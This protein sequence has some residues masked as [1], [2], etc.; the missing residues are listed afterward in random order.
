MTI[1]AHTSLVAAIAVNASQAADPGVYDRGDYR[2][3]QVMAMVISRSDAALDAHL[4]GLE[5]APL[6]VALELHKD[7]LRRYR[8]SADTARE[9]Y[10]VFDHASMMAG[11]QGMEEEA[12]TL[13]HARDE[14]RR[15]ARKLHAQYLAD[16][17]AIAF[18]APPGAIDRVRRARDRALARALVLPHTATEIID[19]IALAR[20]LADPIDVTDLDKEAPTPAVVLL[21]FERAAAPSCTRIIALAEGI[22]RNAS[23]AAARGEQYTREDDASDRQTIARLVEEIRS[24]T[25]RAVAR[26]ANMLPD[27][28]RDQWTLAYNE[29]RW[30]EA[31]EPGPFEA[32]LRSIPRLQNLTDAQR[33]QIDA[34][35][36]QYRRAVD[37]VRA[38]YA[39]CNDELRAAIQ[40]DQQAW[41]QPDR[42]GRLE[43]RAAIDDAIAKVK[44]AKADRETIAK[45]YLQRLLGVL[46]PA[47]AEKLEPS[48]K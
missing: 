33:E 27:T 6:A 31:Y 47:Q 8:D 39:R 28:Q 2:M 30:P 32:V 40:A 4:L 3:R 25:D 11:G 43:R 12:K 14:H 35:R 5:G 13:R 9:A 20:Q 18:E 41:G 42:A 19:P 34:I 1:F 23:E 17:E 22:L 38:R 48:G 45:R 46:T 21:E 24:L 16:L 7:Y 37:P 15:I 10:R 44:D 26:V 29:R 36:Q